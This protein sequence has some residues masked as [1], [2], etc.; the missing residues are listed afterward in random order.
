MTRAIPNKPSVEPVTELQP[1][2][3]WL[4]QVWVGAVLLLDVGSGVANASEGPPS[5]FG[6]LDEFRS[7]WFASAAVGTSAGK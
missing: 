3:E 6:V 1:P 5:G 7:T 4:T 2:V